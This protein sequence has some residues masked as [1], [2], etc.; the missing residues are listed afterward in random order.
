[1]LSRVANQQSWLY[2]SICSEYRS[3]AKVAKRAVRSEK[4]QHVAALVADAERADAVHDIR[5]CYSII[6]RLAPKPRMPMLTARNPAAGDPCF[7]DEEDQQVR[8]EALCSIFDAKEMPVDDVG[9]PQEIIDAPDEDLIGQY[10]ANAV[11]QALERPPNF[12]SAPVL[13]WTDPVTSQA[14]RQ[15]P[16]GAAVELWKLSTE[17]TGVPLLG[18]FQAAQAHRRAPQRFKDGETVSLR[19]PKGDG[20]NAKDHY[21]TI[22]L[23]GHAGKA[24]TNVTIMPELRQT[25]SK[26]SST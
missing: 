14:P 8:T 16:E 1:M 12:K 19:K 22:N 20:S 18:V 23:I 10:D 6:K 26:L 25:S 2:K 17:I 7:D 11:T 15:D 9:G 5:R 21:R 3:A 4:R 24:F 13:K